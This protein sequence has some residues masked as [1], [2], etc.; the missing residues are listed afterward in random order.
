MLCEST[1]DASVALCPE[2][3]AR[4]VPDAQCPTGDC[5]TSQGWSA[6]TPAGKPAHPRPPPAQTIRVPPEESNRNLPANR[7]KSRSAR[8]ADTGLSAECAWFAPSEPGRRYSLV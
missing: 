8:V 3:V 5:R 2:E 4:A 1:C 7:E 6:T